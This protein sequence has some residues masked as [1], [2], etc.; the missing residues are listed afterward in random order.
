MHDG[1]EKNVRLWGHAWLLMVVAF[2]VHVFDEV[3]TD[4]L[5]LYNSLVTDLRESFG[6]VPFPTFRFGLWLTGLIGGIALL[7]ALTPLVYSGRKILLYVSYALAVIMTL[8]GL[9]HIGASVYWSRVV[10]GAVSSP[11]LVVAAVALLVATIRAHRAS[12]TKRN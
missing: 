9:A 3:M 12:G 7:S 4:F 8:N 10:P 2:T 11:L 5:P 6:F 1:V